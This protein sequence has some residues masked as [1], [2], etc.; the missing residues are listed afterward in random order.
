[1]KSAKVHIRVE[2]SRKSFESENRVMPF[3]AIRAKFFTIAM[4]V[5]LTSAQAVQAQY[6]CNQTL[7][8]NYGYQGPSNYGQPG[9]FPGQNNNF[10]S[11]YYSPNVYSP[12]NYSSMPSISVPSAYTQQMAIPNQSFYSSSVNYSSP[13]HSHHNWHPGHYMMGHY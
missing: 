1:M 6:P 9:M 13:H 8:S 7:G 4:F 10:S 11:N 12:N 3:F 5:G 2:K